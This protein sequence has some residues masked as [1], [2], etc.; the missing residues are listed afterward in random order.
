[1]RAELSALTLTWLALLPSL[2]FAWGGFTPHPTSALGHRYVC[3]R[4]EGHVGQQLRLWGQESCPLLCGGDGVS[5][6]PHCL[7]LC[8]LDLSSTNQPTQIQQD[9][10]G[11]SL[12]SE[13][14][15]YAVVSRCR[16]LN[17]LVA[18]IQIFLK[19]HP[20]HISQLTRDIQQTNINQHVEQESS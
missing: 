5:P 14:R 17:A 15:D 16:S 10:E 6:S 8:Y 12:Q 7:P 11:F 1:M 19:T 9:S 2:C 20:G 3:P 18:G 4:Q 13:M